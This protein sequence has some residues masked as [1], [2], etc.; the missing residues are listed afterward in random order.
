MLYTSKE[1]GYMQ[2]WYT[3]IYSYRMNTNYHLKFV[4]Q[5]KSY[6][7]SNSTANSRDRKFFKLEDIDVI[8][9]E[10]HIYEYAILCLFNIY[11]YN[12]ISAGN[13]GKLLWALRAY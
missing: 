7:E 12:A 8:R 6:K 3:S 1:T 11:L 5:L 4:L 10:Y 2:Y 9:N 13:S